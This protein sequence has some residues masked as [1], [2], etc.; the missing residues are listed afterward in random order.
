[1]KWKKDITK[2]FG[3]MN[4]S[5]FCV[6]KY[7]RYF[8]YNWR[9]DFPKIFFDK[10]VFLEKH[11]IFEILLLFFLCIFLVGLLSFW[12]KKEK[13]KK[14]FGKNVNILSVYK[15]DLLTERKMWYCLRNNSVEKKTLGKNW[16][17]CR[18]NFQ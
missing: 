14:Y 2:K 18:K 12:V 1:M 13:N 17:K 4:Y 15:R 5:F 8:C 9:N 3:V 6:R 16:Q 7:L 11:E 10:N